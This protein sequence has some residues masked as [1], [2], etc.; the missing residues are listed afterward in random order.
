MAK[1]LQ[2]EM[3]MSDTTRSAVPGLWII[4]L[5]IAI[6]CGALALDMPVLNDLVFRVATMMI[7]G[8][9]WNLMANS[10]LV[11]LGHS[12]Y[13]GVGSYACVLVVNR[14]GYPDRA[15]AIDHLRNEAQLLKQLHHRNIV[16]FW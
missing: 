14:T 7:L 11:S 8:T 6:L 13:W 3:R 16:R 1:P 10:G 4:S 5:L 2:T 9:S 15:K 12:A